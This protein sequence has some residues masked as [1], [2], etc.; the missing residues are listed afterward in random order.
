[1]K[2]VLFLIAM[3]S[4]LITPALAQFDGNNNLKFLNGDVSAFVGQTLLANDSFTMKF[5]VNPS[6]AG[7]ETFIVVAGDYDAEI[8]IDSA[9]TISY[10]DFITCNSEAMS[11]GW[12][13]ITT[14]LGV[15]NNLPPNSV[16]TLPQLF[17]GTL[18]NNA[19]SSEF[20]LFDNFSIIEPSFFGLPANWTLKFASLNDN[21]NYAHIFL[22]PDGLT[23]TQSYLNPTGERSLRQSNPT[24]LLTNLTNK[25]VNTTIVF[26]TNSSLN[27]TF[28][29][30]TVFIANN[31]NPIQTGT[32]VGQTVYLNESSVTEISRCNSF[33]LTVN[34]TSCTIERTGN[35]W[36][37]NN[38]AVISSLVDNFSLVLSV[39][40]AG[41]LDANLIVENT[42]V[43]VL[44]SEPSTYSN[45]LITNPDFRAINPDFP[46]HP[47][48][49]I[50]IANPSF[51]I[52]QTDSSGGRQ[53]ENSLVIPVGWF[54][55]GITEDTENWSITKAFVNTPP[56]SPAPLIT[57]AA[58]AVVGVT[59]L[60]VAVGLMLF[61][62]AFIGF[63]AMAFTDDPKKAMSLFAVGIVA[64]AVGIALV[65]VYNEAVNSALS[66]TG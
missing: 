19:P 29:D 16:L 8:D 22:M 4:I 54:F 48:I 25:T 65:G 32:F 23:Y 47:I 37:L 56:V 64:L 46:P 39:G 2:N 42:S 63:G 6:N 55:K 18:G 43:T 21:M 5:M 14:T 17:I 59:P 41:N 57:G 49:E 7:T 13:L 35:E 58:A 61:G 60:L 51:E 3:F 66:V 31:D 10:C 50:P 12:Y 28:V 53:N 40:T 11:G 33:G 62:L 1:M 26:N 9:G 24:K 34:I 45:N 52:T 30:F 20:A 44:V 38:I 27:T 36:T 15:N